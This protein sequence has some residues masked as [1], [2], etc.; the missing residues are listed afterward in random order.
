MAL[1]TKT[2]QQY[3][4]NDPARDITTPVDK[5]PD[6][7][8]P[9]PRA[10]VPEPDN[11]LPETRVVASTEPQSVNEPLPQ[12]V[13]GAR[14]GMSTPT[15]NDSIVSASTS[16]QKNTPKKPPKKTQKKMQKKTAQKKRKITTER[17]S[18]SESSDKSDY[19][20]NDSTDESPDRS[21]NQNSKCLYY[22]GLFF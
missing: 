13:D 12:S 7:P 2:F 6:N 5:I 16:L 15:M 14:P 9:E 19:S 11:C 18:S 20:V 22:N 8:I 1:L 3:P 10:V 17:K 4:S 21:Q